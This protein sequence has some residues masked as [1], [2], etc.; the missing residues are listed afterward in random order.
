[1]DYKFKTEP[2]AHQIKA[3]EMSWNRQYFSYFI[4]IVTGK[5]KVLIE[6]LAMLYDKCKSD[7][8]LIVAPKGVVKTG[9]MVKFLHTYLIT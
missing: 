6:N 4:E 1:M 8:A 7:C 3:L 9:M 5:T 2:Y